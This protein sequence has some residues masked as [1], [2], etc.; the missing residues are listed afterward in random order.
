[1]RAF[2][3]PVFVYLTLVFLSGALVGALAH[4]FYTVQTVKARPAPPSPEQMRRQYVEDL[5]TRLKLSDVQR[6]QLEEILEATG[7]RF[8][9]LRKKWGPETRAIQEEQT[10][11][12]RGI[13]DEAQR[14]EYEKMRQEREQRRRKGGPERGFGP[15]P[16]HG[17]GSKPGP[18]R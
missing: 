11:K 10:E 14:A 15:K 6:G 13:L 9:E 16:G 5:R 3:L 7:R 17:P 1:M 4:R 2:R 18:P 8:H 12:I